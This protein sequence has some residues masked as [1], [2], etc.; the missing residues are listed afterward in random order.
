MKIT[1]FD[2]HI[3]TAHPED[4]ISLFASL[5]FEE[6]HDL[7]DA[8]GWTGPQMKRLTDENGFHVDIASS[9]GREEDLTD[10]TLTQDLT[11]IRMNVDNFDEAYDLLTAHGFKVLNP[12]GKVRTE[13]MITSLMQAPSGFAILLIQH[14]KDHK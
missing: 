14:I 5:G 10:M 12:T 1:T 7:K 2:P 3:A 6:R 8:A 4:V 9:K 11:A 13:F